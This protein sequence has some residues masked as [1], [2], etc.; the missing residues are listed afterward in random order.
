MG[1]RDR[2]DLI[3]P[4]RVGVAGRRK[5]QQQNAGHE[6]NTP[7]HETRPQVAPQTMRPPDAR[8]KPAPVHNRAFMADSSAISAFSLGWSSTP[9]A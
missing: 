8:F 7:Q 9:A 5:R 1:E 6:N 4:P 2:I 3:P